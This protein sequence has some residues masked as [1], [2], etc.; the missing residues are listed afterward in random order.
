MYLIFDEQGLVLFPGILFY[1]LSQNSLHLLKRGSYAHLGS[2]RIQLTA[3]IGYEALE[4]LLLLEKHFLN[5][6]L[7]VWKLG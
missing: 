1:V 7:W 3:R 5:W 4:T 6:S 2:L